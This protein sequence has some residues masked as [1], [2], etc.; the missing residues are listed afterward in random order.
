[1]PIKFKPIQY[2]AVYSADLKMFGDW[3]DRGKFGKRAKE[4]KT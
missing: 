4:Y 3:G 1:M 2:S